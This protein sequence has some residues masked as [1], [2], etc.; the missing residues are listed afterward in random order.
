MARGNFAKKTYLAIHQGKIVERVGQTTKREKVLELCPPHAQPR[1]ILDK[2]GN[3]TKT[4]FEVRTDYVEGI[5]TGVWLK[6]GEY[7]WELNIR[8]RD[9]TDEFI[10]SIPANSDYFKHFAKKAQNIK[11]PE[12]PVMFAPF[13]FVA[14]DGA[15]RRGIT[16]SQGG[17]PVEWYFTKEDKHGMP[18][19]RKAPKNVPY[20]EWPEEIKDEY[21][22]YMKK[23]DRW[24]RN[25]V[26]NDVA[27]MFVGNDLPDVMPE[28][29]KQSFSTPKEE[30]VEEEFEADDLPF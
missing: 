1:E 21:V 19:F 24:L 7:G 4:V 14:K 22:L 8:M 15:R 18:E 29:P 13:D 11:K 10:L 25:Y 12:A 3:Y 9:M 26:V 30:Q 23:R 5:I 16:I 2:N 27:P 17:N 28:V 20:S 6:E